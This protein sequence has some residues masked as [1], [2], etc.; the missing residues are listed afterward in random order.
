MSVVSLTNVSILDNPASFLSPFKFEITFDVITELKEGQG[1]ANMQRVDMLPDLEFKLTYVGSAES[2]EKDQVLDSVM[3]GP[4]PVGISRFV[5]EVRTQQTPSDDIADLFSEQA[6]PPNID[7]LPQNDIVGVT[8]VFLTCSYKDNEFIRVGYLVNVD[9]N[10][11]ELRE[12]PP[13]KTEIDKLERNILTDKPRVTRFNI[14]W[15]DEDVPPAN[16]NETEVGEG[17]GKEE[18]DE[19][20]EE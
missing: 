15:D 2:D 20:K 17:A 16:E 13:E 19:E 3:V 14:K 6:D 1:N 10:T 12:N 7:L 4:V 11:E 8:V 9:Y 18:K 5:L